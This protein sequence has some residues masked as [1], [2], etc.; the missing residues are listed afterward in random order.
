MLSF[1][2]YF[3]PHFA[4][5]FGRVGLRFVPLSKSQGWWCLG[6]FSIFSVYS[7]PCTVLNFHRCLWRQWRFLSSHHSRTQGPRSLPLIIVILCSSYGLFLVFSVRLRVQMRCRQPRA[8][9]TLTPELL[10]L[11]ISAD[12]VWFFSKVEA[13][14]RFRAVDF[15]LILF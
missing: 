3:L 10:I 8:P 6:S 1:T 11:Y 4:A 5:C 9:Q 14:E 7:T 15:S 12:I 2:H 13:V